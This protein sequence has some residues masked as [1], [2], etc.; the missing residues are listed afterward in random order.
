MP[1]FHLY[2]KCQE[3][4]VLWPNKNVSFLL[5]NPYFRVF[6]LAQSEISPITVPNAG[7]LEFRVICWG[8]T[9]NGQ[10]MPDSALNRKF[11]VNSFLMAADKSIILFYW[12][13]R[14]IP[15]IR[16]GVAWPLK[17]VEM[18]PIGRWFSHFSSFS[19]R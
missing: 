3:I 1:D 17:M 9:K 5:V 7:G 11:S 14:A 2:Y 12:P 19:S 10:N 8:W 15:R 18:C 6:L 13:Y 16:F 4:A